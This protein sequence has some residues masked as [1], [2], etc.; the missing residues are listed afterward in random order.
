MPL[1]FPDRE[2][3]LLFVDSLPVVSESDAIQEAYVSMRLDGQSHNWAEMCAHRQAPGTK[4]SDRTFQE[5]IGAGQFLD[6]M[7][8]MIRKA[9]M[10]AYEK[11]TGRKVPEG[12]RYLSTLARFPG[13]PKAWV[14]DVG[15]AKARFKEF[16]KG[17]EDL[18]IEARELPPP[19]KVRIAE[20]IV[21]RH[22]QKAVADPA[23]A[24]KDKREL[25]EA[26]IDKHSFSES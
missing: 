15:E 10:A 5:G 9:R 14:T 6:K 11:A 19:P 21:Q 23:N 26:I 7:P 22:L 24:G 1:E 17:C 16:G 4:N 13:D 20:D 2:A 25:R 3:L 8:P 12:A 18:G